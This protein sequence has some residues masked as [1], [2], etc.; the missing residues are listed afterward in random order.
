TVSDVHI[1]LFRDPRGRR[2]VLRL[3]SDGSA[4]V[5]IPRGGSIAE[6]RRFVGRQK[7][8]LERQLQRLLSRPVLPREWILGSDVLF[9][10]ER[11]KLERANGE[12]GTVRLGTERVG[13]SGFSTDLRPAIERHLWRLASK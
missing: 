13:L 1:D 4:R 3:R 6:A 7:M 9:R 8:W 10:G 12:N 11:L 5:T 2:Y